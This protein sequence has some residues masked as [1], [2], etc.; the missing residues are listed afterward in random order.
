MRDQWVK[1][2]IEKMMAKP[3]L[4][5][6]SKKI[7]RNVVHTFTEVEGSDFSA[8]EVG[9]TGSK[10]TALRGLY[11]HEPSLSMAVQLWEKRQA[12]RKYGS[13]G[14]HCY[15]HLLKSHAQ[16]ENTAKRSSLMGPCLQAVTLTCV[17]RVRCEVNV[18]YRTTEILKKFPAD[19][20][21]I[22]DMMLPRFNFTNI[23][24]G[25]VTCHWV[26]LTMSPMYVGILAP[27][28]PDFVEL[29]EELAEADP[30]FHSHAIRAM[31]SYI[32]H[33]VINKETHKFNQSR[34]TAMG[35]RKLL[36]D[37]QVKTIL[38][39]CESVIGE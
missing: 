9:Y 12:S 16:L 28:V 25:G 15:N 20:V 17:D 30:R 33:E 23:H 35:I 1:L 22:R 39:Y 10:M 3:D 7:F 24:L 18:F 37:N 34:R 38:S 8:G 19:L 4:W 31:H 6:G 5:D 29:M 32:R 2:A 13:V 36:S 26:N 21:M 27:L 11:I 14:F